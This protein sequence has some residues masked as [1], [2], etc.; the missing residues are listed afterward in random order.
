MG[1][2]LVQYFYFLF[3][4]FDSVYFYLNWFGSIE[5]FRFQ[6]YETEIKIESN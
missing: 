6:A 3:F 4:L 1:F 5:V 2:V